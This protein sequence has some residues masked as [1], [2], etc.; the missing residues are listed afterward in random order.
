MSELEQAAAA[1]AAAL[2][3]RGE[4][5][6][7]RE[8]AALYFKCLRELKTAQ[9]E[10]STRPALKENVSPSA[11]SQPEVHHGHDAQRRKR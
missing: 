11:I 5:R 3:A 4:A 10:E 7:A 8:A 1:L 9:K 2:I 6:S